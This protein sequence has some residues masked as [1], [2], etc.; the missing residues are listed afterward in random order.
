M[1]IYL[2]ILLITNQKAVKDLFILTA[3]SRDEGVHWF[4]GLHTA[5][6]P[7]DSTSSN[8]SQLVQLNSTQLF[9]NVKAI[10]HTYTLPAFS[11]GCTHITTPCNCNRRHKWLWI[12]IYL[13]RFPIERIISAQTCQKS[14]TL[15]H[16]CNLTYM[17]TLNY[18]KLRCQK[19]S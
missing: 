10:N 14:K 8:R 9:I 5:N 13:T 16:W 19:T 12:K 7:S 6:Y 11:K 1:Y 17:W 15:F 2:S 18:A 3:G 4:S